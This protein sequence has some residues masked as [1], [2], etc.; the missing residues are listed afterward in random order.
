[1]R[2]ERV[3]GQS[4][5]VPVPQLRKDIG[6]VIKLISKERVSECIIEQFTDVPVPHVQE[7]LVEMVQPIMQDRISDRVVEQIV[8]VLVTEIRGHIDEVVKVMPKEFDGRKLESTKKDGF[9]L[10]DENEKNKLEELKAIIVV[11]DDAECIKKS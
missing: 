11:G 7:K 2:P 3:V 6:E 9:D 4:V 5:V 8:D 1:M 10:G